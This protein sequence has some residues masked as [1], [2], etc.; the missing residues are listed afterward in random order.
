[1]LPLYRLQADI[2]NPE[3]TGLYFEKFLNAWILNNIAVQIKPE[4]KYLFFQNVIKYRNWNNT[5][6]ENL[7]A[8]RERQLR[9]ASRIQARVLSAKTRSRLVVGLG[10]N[11]PSEAGFIWHR[12]LGV[13][14]I[15]ASSVKGMM[16]A[17]LHPDFPWGET[18]ID[19]EEINRNIRRLFGDV[20]DGIGSLI[21]FDAFPKCVPQLE[22]DV[23]TPHYG[24][25][26]TNPKKFPPADYYQPTP[27]PFLT[28]A[29]NQTFE[30]IIAT[31]E[32]GS[33]GAE[34]VLSEGTEL[35]SKGLESLGLGAKTAVGYG[36][37]K[38]VREVTDEV[39]NSIRKQEAESARAEFERQLADLPPILK[40][41]KTLRYNV[42]QQFVDE[43]TAMQELSPLFT[44]ID[45]LKDAE[46]RT[47]L[48]QEMVEIMK[49]LNKWEGK[50]S[51]KNAKKKEV[52]Q[53]ILGFN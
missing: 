14:Y 11:H 12:N 10:S 50:Q 32:P 35:L 43:Q 48:A 39:L 18:A 40:Q 9:L 23:M 2:T 7:T 26:Y 4:D 28:V 13:P 30:F 29:P 22:V 27:V 46:V 41:A 38:D 49:V 19:D 25:Y 15:P 42:E 16:K 5:S 52:L 34:A 47:E 33:G 21:L 1:M 36:V 44:N 3:N 37:F 17:F 8:Y 31:R 6:A 24:D 20:K 53:K 51:Q 45:T